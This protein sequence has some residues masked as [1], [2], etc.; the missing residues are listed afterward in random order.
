MMRAEP[1]VTLD[2]GRHAY[3][4]VGASSF[5]QCPGGEVT[6]GIITGAVVGGILWAGSHGTSYPEALSWSDVGVGSLLGAG[7]GLFAALTVSTVLA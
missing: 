3:V 7:I 4:R 1:R 2:P 6:T 5:D